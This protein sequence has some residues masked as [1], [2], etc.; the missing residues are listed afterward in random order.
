MIRM[1]KGKRSKWRRA[2]RPDTFLFTLVVTCVLLLASV[3][4]RGEV[5]QILRLEALFTEAS[6]EQGDF[7]PTSADN[8]TMP[9]PWTDDKVNALLGS[10]PDAAKCTP[11]KFLMLNAHNYFVPED[12]Q[13]SRY[14]LVHKKEESRQAVAHVIASQQPHV[15]GLIEMGGTH[16]LADL[17]QRLNNMGV[18]YPYS[19]ILLRSGEDRALALLSQYPIIQDHSKANCSLLGKKRQKMLRGILDVTILV[20]EHRLYR[21]VGAHLKSRVSDNP[22]AATAQRTAEART[23][24]AYLQQEMRRQPAMPMVVYG[25]WNDG[26]ADSSL[27]ILTQGFSEDAAL[28]RVKAADSRGE[29]W[30]IYSDVAD[31]YCVFDQV[32]V[33]SV[34]KSR[35]G[36]KCG[37]GVVDVEETAAASDHRA[38]WCELR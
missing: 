13:R 24:A 9:A 38:V 31:E 2:L 10:M 1:G 17:Q 28:S 11:I 36:R 35:R 8:V 22:A 32:Y 34:M 15:V 33:N 5:G 19:K 37:S 12:K 18:Q 6:Q 3:F 14:R 27:S 23:I 26:P 7:G 30:T 16:A 4:G 29:R 25:D 21:I 20:D